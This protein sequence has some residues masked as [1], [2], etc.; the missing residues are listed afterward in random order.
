MKSN[1]KK[2]VQIKHSLEL[3]EL[4]ISEE[5][6]KLLKQL[7]EIEKYKKKTKNVSIETY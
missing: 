2:T 4:L 5:M 7:E 6:Q 1:K 3:R